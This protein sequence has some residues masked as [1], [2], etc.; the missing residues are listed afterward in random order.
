MAPNR[1]MRNKIYAQVIKMVL[2]DAPTIL[3]VDGL[4]T[5]A[6]RNYVKGIYLDSAHTVFPVKYAWLD[7]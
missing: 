2:D 4:S 1:E 6:V 3:L 7:Q 5:I